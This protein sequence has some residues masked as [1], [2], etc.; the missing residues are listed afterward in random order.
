MQEKQTY[1]ERVEEIKNDK[2][3]NHQGRRVALAKLKKEP[4]DARKQRARDIAEEQKYAK[5]KKVERRV[6]KAKTRKESMEKIKRPTKIQLLKRK[7]YAMRMCAKEIHAL[8]FRR[9]QQRKTALTK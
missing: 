5:A 9:K 3:L 1:E 2:S 6:E 4:S 7:I 8:R